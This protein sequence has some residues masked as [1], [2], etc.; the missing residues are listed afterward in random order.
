MGA[1]VAVRVDHAA[2]AKTCR[3]IAAEI[4]SWDAG[5]AF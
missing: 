2:A 1:W 3:A 5:T 4:D